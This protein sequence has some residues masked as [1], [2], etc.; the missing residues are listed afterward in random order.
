MFQTV[1]CTNN[2]DVDLDWECWLQCYGDAVKTCV[3]KITVRRSNIALGIY[4]LGLTQVKRLKRRQACTIVRN[5][6]H[7]KLIHHWN[8][9]RKVR[10]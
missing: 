2:I 4:H 6:I 9:F 5:L 7:W 8:K 10:N 1:E 3:P